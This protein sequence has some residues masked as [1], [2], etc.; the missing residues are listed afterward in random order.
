MIRQGKISSFENGYVRITF[1]SLD[2]VVS[3][4][5]SLATHISIE[6]LNIGDT[7]LVAFYNNDLKSGIII[8]KSR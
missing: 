3:P 1:P 7:V 8:A 4:P 6:S 5:L 2:N